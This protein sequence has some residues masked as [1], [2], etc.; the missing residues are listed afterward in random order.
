MESCASLL[1]SVIANVTDGALRL[2]IDA[3]RACDPSAAPGPATSSPETRTSEGNRV[4]GSIWAS[5][6]ARG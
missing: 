1:G 6:Q 2:A 5:K 3:P 4:R